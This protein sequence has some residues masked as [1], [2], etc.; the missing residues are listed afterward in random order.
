MIIIKVDYREKSL[1]KLL[2]LFK[3]DYEYKNVEIIVENLPLGDVTI[4][5]KHNAKT[6]EP[7]SNKEIE[8]LIIFERKTLNDLASSIRDGRYAEQSYR[9]NKIDQPNHN[10]VYIV[11]GDVQF[12]GN[13]YTNIKPQTLYV[14]M[15][16]INFFK[17]FSLFKSKNERETAEY[18]LRISDKL[19]RE[20]KKQGYYVKKKRET[21]ETD[22]PNDTN[23]DDSNNKEQN[24]NSDTSIDRQRYVDVKSRV[25]KDHITPDNIGEI[26]L[27]QIPGV[28]AF[29][30][31]VIMSHFES[32]HDLLNKLKEDPSCLDDIK[33]KLKSGQERRIT[34]K[35]IVNI[36]K[37]LLYQKD[38]DIVVNTE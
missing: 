3:E 1:I 24:E 34:K 9:L 23:K 37:Y 26:I 38:T 28:S 10:I 33:Y 20:T 5:K 2:K 6:R 18:L 36:I 27:S 22:D 14:T 4:S 30:S 7:G 32:L 17:G 12:W 29:I 11:E 8:E 16:C 15:F 19:N 35:S 31:K 13:R 25:K 21:T